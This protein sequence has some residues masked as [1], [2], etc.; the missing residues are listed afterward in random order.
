LTEQ[1]SIGIFD[2]GLTIFAAG[3]VGNGVAFI[4]GTVPLLEIDVAVIDFQITGTA[5]GADAV[6]FAAAPGDSNV[7]VDTDGLNPDNAL[8]VVGTAAQGDGKGKAKDFKQLYRMLYHN[9]RQPKRWGF[10]ANS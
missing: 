5:F 8:A 7:D 1:V 6:A 2:I 10:H 9:A 3:Q 4:S